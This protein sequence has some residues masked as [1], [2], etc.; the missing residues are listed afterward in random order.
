MKKPRQAKHV[1]I[2]GDLVQQNRAL[3]RMLLVSAV[4]TFVAVS[5]T[6]WVMATALKKPLIYYVDSSGE[7]RYG[8]RLQDASQPLEVEVVFVVKEF[9]RRSVAFN[10]L[11]IERDLAAGFNLMTAELQA[12]EK[13]QLETYKVNR[14][15]SWVEYVQGQR[16]RTDIDFSELDIESHGGELFSVRTQGTLKTWPLGAGREAAPQR[17]DFESQISIRSVKR[18]EQ[19][20]NGLLVSHRAIQFY[21]VEDAAEDLEAVKGLTP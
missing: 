4:I 9:L 18:T 8:G 2:W 17:R 10:S 15:Q 1:E 14:G 5:G 20:P 7:A 16:I 21:E 11:T 3:T 13:A 19:T 6:T 12:E